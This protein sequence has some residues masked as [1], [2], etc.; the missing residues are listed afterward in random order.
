[1]SYL[2]ETRTMTLM[3]LL[4]DALEGKIRVRTFLFELKSKKQPGAEVPGRE[5]SKVEKSSRANTNLHIELRGKR[6]I[7]NTI[8]FLRNIYRLC[9]IQYKS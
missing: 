9:A 8:F 5:P 6:I 3:H 1:M 7:K 2:D 4:H